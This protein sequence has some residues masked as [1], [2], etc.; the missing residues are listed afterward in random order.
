MLARTDTLKALRDLISDHL[1]TVFSRADKTDIEAVIAGVREQAKEIVG[2]AVL[3]DDVL[4]FCA[5]G[6]VKKRAQP[7]ADLSHNQG[8]MFGGLLEQLVYH[9]DGSFGPMGRATW[10][11][12]ITRRERQIKNMR[13]VHNV[14]E[15]EE[16]LREKVR[17]LME[18]DETL[19]L[20]E[21]LA[22]IREP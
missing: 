22:K 5:E 14:F 19:V 10:R 7:R 3:M 11:V 4:R 16:R 18:A 21:A 1:D 8:D 15:T 12:L 20:E 2:E 13:D 6:V 17:P 9:G